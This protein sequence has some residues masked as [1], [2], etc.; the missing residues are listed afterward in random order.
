MLACLIAIVFAQ[1][2]SA[3]LCL[4]TLE[5]FHSLRSLISFIAGGFFLRKKPLRIMV[6]GYSNCGTAVVGN[7]GDFL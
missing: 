4:Y 2:L 3:L 5:R 6:S 1:T 7:S